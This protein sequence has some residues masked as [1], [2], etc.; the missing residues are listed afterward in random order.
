MEGLTEEAS[1]CSS[2][3]AFAA[4][5]S[6]SLHLLLL[7]LPR[8]EPCVHLC[9]KDHRHGKQEREK[10]EKTKEEREERRRH[11]EMRGKATECFCFVLFL[12]VS[13]L[14]LFLRLYESHVLLCEMKYHLQAAEEERGENKQDMTDGHDKDEKGKQMQEKV[15]GSKENSRTF[16]I[17]QRGAARRYIFR[18]QKMKEEREERSKK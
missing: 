12:S 7:F 6:P 11:G 18:R 9:E 1:E 13:L 17:M 8:S 4:S 15:R 3:R 2:G 14:L 5:P 16:I 10:E